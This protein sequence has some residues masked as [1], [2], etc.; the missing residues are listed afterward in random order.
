MTIKTYHYYLV[1]AV[2]FVA[3]I[4]LVVTALEVAVHMFP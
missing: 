2:A 1:G 4:T 3:W